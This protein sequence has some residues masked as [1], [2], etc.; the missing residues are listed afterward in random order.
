MEL[1]LR[2]TISAPREQRQPKREDGAEATDSEAYGIPAGPAFA[3]E[4]WPRGRARLRP[5]P[6]WTP[7]LLRLP[8]RP[9]LTAAVPMTGRSRVDLRAGSNAEAQ[10]GIAPSSIGKN[11]QTTVPVKRVADPRLSPDR[12][13]LGRPKRSGHGDCISLALVARSGSRRYALAWVGRR[14]F[15][16]PSGEVYYACAASGRSLP[17]A[18]P[19]VLLG[20]RKG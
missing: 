16:G 11:T 9:A 6:L 19:G 5:G 10:A 4:E 14:C 3:S 12:G 13:G 18:E 8:L 15:W 1:A 20:N 7:L 17:Q 2:P